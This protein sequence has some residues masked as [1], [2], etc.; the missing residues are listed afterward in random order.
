MSNYHYATSHVELLSTSMRPESRIKIGNHGQFDQS[1]ALLVCMET[2]RI[3]RSLGIKTPASTGTLSLPYD[4]SHDA[5]LYSAPEMSSLIGCDISFL[6]GWSHFQSCVKGFN[7]LG[8]IAEQVVARRI[9]FNSRPNHLKHEILRDYLFSRVDSENVKLV[10]E[11]WLSSASHRELLDSKIVDNYLLWSLFAHRR[12][13]CSTSS[14]MGI[15]LHEVLRL[16]QQTTQQAGP[17]G[18]SIL[19]HDEGSLIIWCPDER[20]DFMNMEKAT[21]LRK[22]ETEEPKLTEL[23]TYINRQQRDPGA[24]RDALGT[25]GFFFPTN[26]Q[27]I[28]EIQGLLYATILEGSD[29]PY[30]RISEAINDP[31]HA[32]TLKSLGCEIDVDNMVILVQR[33]VEGGIFGLMVPYFL[34]LEESLQT[35]A[36]LNLEVWNQASIGAALAA[37]VLADNIFR[38]PHQLSSEVRSEFENL[39][40]LMSEIMRS[41]F[42]AKER[43]K[44]AIHGIFDIANIQSLAQLLGVVVTRHLAGRSTAFVGL[45][46]SSYSNGNRC[47]EILD[48]SVSKSQ[49]F[50]GRESFHPAT[51]TLNPIA[52]A[53]VFGEELARLIKVKGPGITDNQILKHCKK[54]EPAGA[55][56]LAGF[57]LHKL[58]TNDLSIFE[59]GESL[60]KFGFNKMLFLEFAGFMPNAEGEDTFIQSAYEEGPYMGEMA[61]D[62]MQVLDFPL[63]MLSNL[64]ETHRKERSIAKI[65]YSDQAKICIYLTGDN[66]RQP[67]TELIR[68]IYDLRMDILK[69]ES[70]PP[71]QTNH[72]ES[73]TGHTLLTRLVRI[74]RNVF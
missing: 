15:S 8:L 32:Q 47:F 19:N 12:I 61:C 37:A 48:E 53:L 51:H 23:H 46:S 49:S 18:Y 20:A 7:A 67:N 65:G 22:L 70:N 30:H 73:Q 10:S 58:D 1:H 38:D 54:P 4:Q 52:Q 39:F 42:K 40:P 72:G 2:I 29:D 5:I 33:G 27:S 6:R 60:K 45:G 63:P 34:M 44:I 31:N 14:N 17:F 24:L 69:G 59:I 62:L 11:A 35:S 66:A 71:K 43:S 36:P 26:P 55:A 68:K 25:G 50:I 13:V 57:L 3:A 16:M 74:Y 21:L 56:A 9:E 28:D 41:R 64:S